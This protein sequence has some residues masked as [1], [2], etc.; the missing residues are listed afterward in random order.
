LLQA[1]GRVRANVPPAPPRRITTVLAS[2]PLPTDDD[3]DR[4]IECAFDT[5]ESTLGRSRAPVFASCREI[6][7]RE[8]IVGIGRRGKRRDVERGSASAANC[9][10]AFDASFEAGARP[11]VVISV[12]RNQSMEFRARAL[13]VPSPREAV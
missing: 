2:A 13:V 9:A 1:S 10:S 5:G 4:E 7:V 3:L 12:V 11:G 6:G 8:T